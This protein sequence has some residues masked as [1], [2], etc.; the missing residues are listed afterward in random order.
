MN[1]CRHCHTWSA[2]RCTCEDQ[3]ADQRALLSRAG[4]DLKCQHCGHVK[5]AYR[6]IYQCLGCDLL[7][8]KIALLSPPPYNWE[9]DG[10]C[11]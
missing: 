8:T 2:A 10:E 3:P 9:V 1:Y 4:D 6:G 5:L 7:V 11:G